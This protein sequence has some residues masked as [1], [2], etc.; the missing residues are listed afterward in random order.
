MHREE[1]V[2]RLNSS[3]ECLLARDR[4]LLEFDVNERSI[5]HKLAEYLQ[6]FFPEYNVDCEYNRNH[7]AVKT[8]EL[9]THLNQWDDTQARTVF[10]DIIVHQRGTDT[11]VL[12]IEVKKTTGG[13]EQF[14]L[15]K[16]SAYRRDLAYEHAAFL[17]LRTGIENPGVEILRFIPE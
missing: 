12:V 11:N 15:D 14:D 4:A 3:I 1:L 7:G 17:K 16:L 6:T 8:L 10:P 2:R 5:T 9:P 13:N